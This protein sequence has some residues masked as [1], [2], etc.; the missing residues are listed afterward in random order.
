MD[1]SQRLEPAT[2]VAQAREREAARELGEHRKLLDALEARLAEL[3][4]YRE[5][6]VQRLREAGQHGI[7]AS[8]LSEYR[9]FIA[10]LDEAVRYQE[11]K[12][13]DAR[14]ELERRRRR[15]GTTRTRVAALDKVVSRYEAQAARAEAQREQKDQDERA[16][17]AGTARVE[18]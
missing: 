9:G 2:R 4:R 10:R 1:R 11:A 16:L 17:R 12:V 3:V 8:A 18:E 7:D 14:T 6:Y 5:E 13:A 15:W